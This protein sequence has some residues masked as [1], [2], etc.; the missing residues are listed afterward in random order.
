MPGTDFE[1][2]RGLRICEYFEETLMKLPG[3]DTL[4]SCKEINLHKAKEIF[5]VDTDQ[6]YD[7]IKS[8]LSISPYIHDILLAYM[9]TK[10][11]KLY[12]PFLQYQ[13][14]LW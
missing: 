14:V 2:L 4:Y 8:Y 3:H 13:Y 12:S 6:L 11:L 7:L 10:V 1:L 5:G 9:D